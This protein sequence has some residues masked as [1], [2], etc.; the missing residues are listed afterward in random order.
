MKALLFTAIVLAAPMHYKATGLVVAVDVPRGFVTVSHERIPGY[1]DAMVMTYHVPDIKMLEGLRAGDKIDFSLVV[2]KTS[3]QLRDI[4]RHPYRSLQPDPATARRLSVLDEA[5]H[6]KTA[7]PAP[8]VIGQAVADFSLLDQDGHT[9]T[10]SSLK[11]KVVGVTFIYTRCPL[12]DFCFRMS[13]NF[14]RLQKRF[15]SHMGRDLVLLSITFDPENDQPE[16]LAKYASIWRINP[17]GWH[18]LTGSVAAVKQVCAAFGMSY[19]HDEGLYT[20]SLHTAVIDRE[21]KL[22]A[23][24]EGNQFTAAQLGDIV[25]SALKR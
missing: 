22:V 5:M 6:A 11:G 12:P 4:S 17:E 8:V 19:W 24:I 1:M 23:N 18:F 7:G 13:T 20:H 3:S 16:V 15:A 9:V 25:E 21:G 14:S 10:L 2:S